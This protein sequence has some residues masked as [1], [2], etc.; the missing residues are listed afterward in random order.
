[1]ELS[2]EKKIEIILKE[3]NEIMRLSGEVLEILSKLKRHE[4]DWRKDFELNDEDN[5]LAR[6]K[7]VQIISHMS[8][9]VGFCDKKSQDYVDNLAVAISE[10]GR[11]GIRGIINRFDKDCIL[12]PFCMMANTL[13]IDFTKKPWKILD[14]E[15]VLG[16]LRARI[17]GSK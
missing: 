5:V 2:D 11:M 9:I 4:D 7:L 1:M 8:T 12:D 3:K 17:K 14:F 15:V 13:K 16:R 10:V 6:Q